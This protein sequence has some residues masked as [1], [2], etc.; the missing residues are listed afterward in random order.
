MSI[1]DKID[2]ILSALKEEEY[3]PMWSLY[4]T[5]FGSNGEDKDLM[6]I[7]NILLTDG[8]IAVT[9]QKG[10]YSI[11]GKGREVVIDG[12]YK[13][14]IKEKREDAKQDKKHREAIRIRDKW[15]SKLAKWQVYLFWPI[16]LLA[17]LGAIGNAEKTWEA[18][19]KYFGAPQEHTNQKEELKASTPPP[20]Q[21]K[22]D[23]LSK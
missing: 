19:N 2:I 18:Y 23:S 14:Y 8:L 15:Q 13:K 1:D 20:S 16:F 5:H 12:G 3:A 10:T 17:L 7:I 9:G 6:P 22:T 11:S 21:T 4:Q